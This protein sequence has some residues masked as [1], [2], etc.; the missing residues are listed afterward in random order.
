MAQLLDK[1]NAALASHERLQTIVISQEAWS[2]G[3]GFLTSTMKIKRSRIE[4]AVSDRITDW[5]QSGEAVIWS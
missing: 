2:I 4:D 1:F 3:N 5:Y